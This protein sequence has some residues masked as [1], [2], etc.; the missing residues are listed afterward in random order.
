MG[1]VARKPVFSICNQIKLNTTCSDISNFEMYHSS[2]GV[3]SKCIVQTAPLSHATKSGFPISKSKYEPAYKILEL[4]INTQ[5]VDR[6]L[7]ELRTLKG[8]YCNEQ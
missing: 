1:R 7:K 4:F 5:C 8:D 6:A 2:E 3:N